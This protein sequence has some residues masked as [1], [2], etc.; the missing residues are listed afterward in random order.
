MTISPSHDASFGKRTGEGRGE[1]GEVAVQW[2]FGAALQVYLGPVLEDDGSKT[3][4]RWLVNPRARRWE[5]V[6]EL[7][8]HGGDGGREG[9]AKGRCTASM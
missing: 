9:G 1:L 5:R 2:L 8:E 7:G 6:G 4:P 3:V